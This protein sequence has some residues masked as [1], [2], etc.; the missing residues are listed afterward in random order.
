MKLSV[1]VDKRQLRSIEK[2]LGEIGVKV[3]RV[4][5]SS[6]NDTTKKQK[7][8]V[9]RQ[10]RQFVNIKKRD[11][12]RHISFSRASVRRP[13][14]EFRVAKGQRLPLKYFGARQTKKGVTYRIS[15]LGK[16]RKM[17]AGAFGPKIP[18]LGGH[19]FRRRGRKRL[20]IVKL[21][22]PSVLAVFHTV[23]TVKQTSKDMSDDLYKAID[24]RVGF[25]LAKFRGSI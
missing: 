11:I 25:E 20:P 13:S 17:I 18:R 21:H 10:I 4:L 16:G 8:K 6:V 9:S 3:P 19:V 22:G 23:R 2:T 5:A 7:T 24:R 1:T 15:R 12:D 14:A